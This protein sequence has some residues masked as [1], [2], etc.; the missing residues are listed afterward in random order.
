MQSPAWITPR[1]AQHRPA[2]RG[3]GNLRAGQF[4][5]EID[6][7]RSH[8]RGTFVELGGIFLVGEEVRVADEEERD[9]FVFRLR[10]VRP[11]PRGEGRAA[12]GGRDELTAVDRT[13]HLLPCCN[14]FDRREGSL[15]G[16]EVR[17]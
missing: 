4:V 17:L 15:R 6:E 2:A 11:E 9:R 7:P 16:L 13:G 5:E 10:L 1:D 3:F 12:R 8:T 14:E